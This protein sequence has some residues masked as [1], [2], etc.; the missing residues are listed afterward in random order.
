MASAGVDSLLTRDG[1]GGRLRQLHDGGFPLILLTHWQSL[2]TNG[3]CAGL[4][5]MAK[6]L[7]RIERVFGDAVCWKRCSALA[8]AALAQTG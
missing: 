6:L 3:R 4:G 7:D 1:K 8:R 5:G 2:F